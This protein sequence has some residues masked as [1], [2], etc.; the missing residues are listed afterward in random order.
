MYSR[1]HAC[2]NGTDGLL[3]GTGEGGGA[4]ACVW[5][6]AAT[7]RRAGTAMARAGARKKSLQG[8]G[9]RL[10]GGGCRVRSKRAP[11]RTRADAQAKKRARANPFFSPWFCLPA[12]VS[13]ANLARA[14]RGPSENGARVHAS[15]RRTHAVFFFFKKKGGLLFSR[16]RISLAPPFFFPCVRAPFKRELACARLEGF[17]L[18]RPAAR[19]AGGRD[20]PA[21]G[22]RLH[23]VCSDRGSRGGGRAV[24]RTVR[25]AAVSCRDGA[26]P[27]AC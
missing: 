1:G 24:R 15:F 20:V 23:H 10:G 5:A 6:R 18:T 27:G 16:M 8:G 22:R 21:L 13:Q 19:L 11:Q 3:C 2:E 25:A 14:A 7:R 4:W 17:V 12:A 26:L 9:K